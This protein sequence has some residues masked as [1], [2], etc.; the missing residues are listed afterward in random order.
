MPHMRQ[1]TFY[2]QWSWQPQYPT[3]R[4]KHER[5]AESDSMNLCACT[6]YDSDNGNPQWETGRSRLGGTVERLWG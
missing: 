3:V 5:T 2:S 6:L 1:Y 4:A